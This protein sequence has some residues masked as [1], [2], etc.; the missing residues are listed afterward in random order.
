RTTGRS[1]RRRGEAFIPPSRSPPACTPAPRPRGRPPPA[2]A[3][4]ATLFRGLGIFPHGLPPGLASSMVR[5][6]SLRG[7][8][9]PARRRTSCMFENLGKRI[10]TFFL[11]LIIALLSLIMAVVG[12]GAPGSEGCNVQGPG[13]A[14]RVYGETITAGDFQAAYR[15]AGFADQPIDTQRAQ[16]WREYLLD[17]LVER[18][19]LVHEA[20]RLGYSIEPAEVMRTVAKD[21]VLL[22]SGP[23]DAPAGFPA[24]RLQYSFRD[25]DDKFSTDRLRR[26]I[27][28]YLRRSVEEFT[29][30]Q[31]RETLAQRMRDTITASVEVSPREVWDA[32]VTET[33]RASISYVRFGP[34]DYRDQVEM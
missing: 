27:Q 17:G 29:E 6:P 8:Y 19:L 5:A 16:R 24:G 22:L 26:F 15:A 32:Y 1:S 12:F 30:W 2:S 31:A 9:A 23:V 18:E 14:A 4:K 21:E 13:Y 28:N 25:R 20:E 11:I 7:L 33:E 34:A 10:Q 3:R